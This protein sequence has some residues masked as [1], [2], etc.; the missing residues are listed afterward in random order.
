M[1]RV[2]AIRKELPSTWQEAL[3]QFLWFKQ[4]QGLSTETIAGYKKD[5]SQFF[6]R[7]PEAW[8]PERLKPLALAYMSEKVKPATFNLRLSYL[9]AF[10]DWCVKEGIFPENP[11]KGIKRRRADGRVVRHTAF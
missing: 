11:L 2:I 4:A 1:G 7:N 5:V 6:R 10:L 9:G 3:E 8:K